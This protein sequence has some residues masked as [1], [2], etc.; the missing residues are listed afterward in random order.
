MGRS[1]YSFIISFIFTLLVLPMG[2]ASVKVDGYFIAQKSCE[3]VHSIKKGT[4]PFTLTKGMAYKV[5][6]KNKPDETH[7]QI[8]I[9]TLETNANK[10]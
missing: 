3:A 2:H 4:H 7:Y 5:T 6:A 1:K 10:W 8:T 9:D